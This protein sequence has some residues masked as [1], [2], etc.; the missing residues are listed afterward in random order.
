[1][2]VEIYELSG[3]RDPVGEYIEAQDPKTKNKMLYQ[4]ERL[5]NVD[6]SSLMRAGILEKIKDSNPG[7]YEL[8]IS[9]NKKE[10]RILGGFVHSQFWLV[11]AFGKKQ[12]KTK[13]SDIVLAEQRLIEIENNQT[14]TWN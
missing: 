6:P 1:M 4:L 10:H 2:K 7:V 14:K 3:G 8:K 9:Y 12:Q 13:N 5:E 11:H